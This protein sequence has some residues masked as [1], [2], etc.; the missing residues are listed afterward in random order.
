MSILKQRLGAIGNENDRI[1]RILQM[2][3]ACEAEFKQFEKEV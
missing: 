2:R 3:E 1:A